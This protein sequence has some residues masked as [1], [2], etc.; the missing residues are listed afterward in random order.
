VRLDDGEQDANPAHTAVVEALA[1]ALNE[2]D[3][4]TASTPSPS[5]SWP[6]PSP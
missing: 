2:R 3:R 6:A 1:G 5:S 4:Y